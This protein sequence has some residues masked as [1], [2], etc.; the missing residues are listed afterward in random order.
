M[1]FES[2]PSE[3]P[4]ELVHADPG[5]AS[6]G[7][8]PCAIKR[9]PTELLVEIFKLLPES[10]LLKHVPLVC[11][12]WHETSLNPILRKRLTLRRETPP[13]MLISSVRSRPLLRILKCPALDHA[14]DTLPSAV[15]VCSYL[16]CLDIGFCTLTEN[17]TDTLAMNL[18]ST[19]VHLNVEG[20][21]TIGFNF[22]T[23]LVR[24]CPRLEALNLS[25]CVSVSDACVQ[26]IA[27]KLTSL[28]RLNLD[29]VLWLSDNALHYL[30]N[31][32][33]FQ[34]GRLTYLWLD[35]F[36]LSS[37][38]VGNFLQELVSLRTWTMGKKD[39]P[40]CKSPD[41]I[42]MQVLWISFCDHLMDSAVQPLS[43]LSGLAALTLRKAQQVTSVGWKNLFASVPM[44]HALP[45]QA[46]QCLEH[47][48]LSEA[49]TVDDSVISSICSCC[50]DRLRSL[51]LNWC[52]ELTDEGLND[53]VFSCHCLRH[54]SL[55]GDHL[56][57]GAPLVNVPSQQPAIKIINLTQ[58]SHIQE[59]ILK[60]LVQMMPHIYVFDYFGERVGGGPNDI[61][62]YDLWR[63]LEK[64]PICAD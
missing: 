64:V 1:S 55:V 3:G 36:E 24:S 44:D 2:S 23:F 13:E 19:L 33:A 8:L 18:P 30:V 20:L 12:F 17:A 9:I 51:T 61:C 41:Q 29:G 14:G 49:P 62:H 38:G 5:V 4:I 52:W 6:N 25:H 53:I 34:E 45:L 54:L 48:D 47:L 28:Q 16:E 31:C 7:D 46:L 21:K 11:E 59:T 58:C 43:S 26:L 40:A 56:I 10:D 63:S 27:N 15:K 22:V 35:G 57:L 50:G 37:A 60:E 32:E 39:R 42:G